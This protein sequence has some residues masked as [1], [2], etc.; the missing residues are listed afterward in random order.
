[1]SSHPSSATALAP[2]S[3]FVRPRQ[4]ERVACFAVQALADPGLLPRVLELFAKRGLVPERFFA[5]SEGRE[6]EAVTLDI[7]VAG[8]D[9]QLTDYVA[10]CL[11]QI[12]HVTAVLTTEKLVA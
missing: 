11:R 2:A 4:A 6:R 3:A 12:P 7:Q 9:P 5:Q 8:F 1:M 10:R